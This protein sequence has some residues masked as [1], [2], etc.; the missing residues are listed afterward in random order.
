MLRQYVTRFACV[1]VPI[2]T[3]LR[4]FLTSFRLPGEAQKIERI[5]EAFAGHYAACN[6]K[7][8][9]HPD[10]GFILSFSIIMLHTDLHNKNVPR[11]MTLP[12]FIANNRGIDEGEDLP[13]ELLENIYS[14][15]RGCE[16]Q[17]A[18]DH[19]FIVQHLVK[20]GMAVVL[21]LWAWAWGWGWGVG[22]VHEGAFVLP[23]VFQT[24]I[25]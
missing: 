2:D 19:T 1:D 20:V 10:T 8:F 3:A 15:I 4:R 7:A 23:L 16:F 22:V 6:P 11:H 24:F 9:R 17:Y 25:P 18:K 12:E 13:R 14:R 21:F 5:V